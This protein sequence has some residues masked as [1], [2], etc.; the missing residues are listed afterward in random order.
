MPNGLL[1]VLYTPYSVDLSDCA[2]AYS[3]LESLG[4]FDLL[5]NNAGVLRM[6]PFLDVKEGDIDL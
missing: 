5:V 4:H 1:S 3:I 6:G 2:K